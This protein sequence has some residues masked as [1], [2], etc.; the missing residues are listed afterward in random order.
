MNYNEEYARYLKMFDDFARDFFDNECKDNRLLK[1]MQ[2]SFFAGG[3]R[4]RPILLLHTVEFLGGNVK[5]ALPFAFALECIHTSSLIHDDLPAMDN[6]TL[7][8]GKPTCHVVYGEAD[9]LL[10]GDALITLA[11]EAAINGIYDENSKA[12]AKLLAEFSGYNG[13]L[14]GQVL[15]KRA[16]KEGGDESELIE[17]YKY[18]TSKLLIVPLLIGSL[19]CGKKFYAEFEELGDNLGRMFQAVDDVLDYTSTA[20]NLGKSVGKDEQENKLT[21]VKLFGLNGA[22]GYIKQLNNKIE[23]I[24]KLHLNS[25]FLKCFTFELYRRGTSDEA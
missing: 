10:A 2:Y 9:A 18:K 20:A 7:R 11:F 5:N 15:D 14:Y 4:I 3:K 13:M 1:A 25:G 12:A 21:A 24:L 16:E 19:L 17:I 23:N 8:R 22:K 6:D